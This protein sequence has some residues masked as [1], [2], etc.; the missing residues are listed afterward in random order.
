MSRP[1]DASSS[2]LF[3]EDLIS[4]DVSPLVN[5]IAGN[6]AVAF[7]G[8]GASMSAGLPSWYDFLI[9][10]L[11]RAKGSSVDHSRWSF[12]DHLLEKGDYL[13][14]AEL[15][16][17]TSKP[18][19]CGQFKTDSHMNVQCDVTFFLPIGKSCWRFSA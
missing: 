9:R 1:D 3:P 13:T 15:S 4:I 5:A 7:V 8:A 14:A 16:P 2:S 12:A 18:T 10:C 6:N 17:G 11:K 19:S